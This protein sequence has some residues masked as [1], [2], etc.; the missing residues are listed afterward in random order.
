MPAFRQNG[1][2]VYFAAFRNHVGFFPTQSG[3]EAFRDEL[4][5]YKTFKR[6]VQF[7]YE[8]P[9]PYDLVEK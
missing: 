4:F 3:I 7:P 5:S 8:K 1:I 9:I 2:L 6:T